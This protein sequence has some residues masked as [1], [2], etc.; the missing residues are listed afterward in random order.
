VK[1]QAESLGVSDEEFGRALGGDAI[2]AAMQ[3]FWEELRDFF[4]KL[5]RTE[6]VTAITKLGEVRDAAIAAAVARV[7]AEADRQIGTLSGNSPESL[8]S[9]PAPSP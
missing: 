6:M 7:S 8:E 3:A 1:P 4:Q 5:R 2:Y 9:T